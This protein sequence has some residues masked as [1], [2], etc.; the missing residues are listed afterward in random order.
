M[1]ANVIATS[2]TSPNG[3]TIE[4]RINNVLDTNLTTLIGHTT[5]DIHNGDLVELKIIA[6]DGANSTNTFT[7]PTPTF[8]T[9]SLDYQTETINLN[10]SNM[11]LP[12]GVTTTNAITIEV[13]GTQGGTQIGSTTINTTR[14]DI[15]TLTTYSFDFSEYAINLELPWQLEC[16]V[17]ETFTHITGVQQVVDSFDNVIVTIPK[18]TTVL[19]IIDSILR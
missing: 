15:P 9:S 11:I 2:S 7:V 12:N 14:G 10:F 8:T 6:S 16:K 19:A 17:N 3:S 4:W 13:V 1:V 18:P 5:A